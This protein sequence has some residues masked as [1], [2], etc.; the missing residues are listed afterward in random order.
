MN[1]R[2]FEPAA[3]D[4]VEY[5]P[6]TRLRPT[7]FVDDRNALVAVATFVYDTNDERREVR[8]WSLIDV[9]SGK[10]RK[11]TVQLA[12]KNDS[13]KKKEKKKQHRQSSYGLD[14]DA[15]PSFCVRAKKEK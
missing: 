12:K 11:K 6:K 5:R 9:S 2:A 15:Q 8:S 14:F 3:A 7:Y 10:E 1:V 4:P 13:K